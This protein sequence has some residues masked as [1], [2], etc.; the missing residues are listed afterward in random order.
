MQRSRPDWLR[1]SLVRDR[2]GCPVCP[3]FRLKRARSLTA[4]D[5]SRVL[6]DGQRSANQI[7]GYKRSQGRWC[8]KR[9]EVSGPKVCDKRQE[10]G[11]GQADE[12]GTTARRGNL[13]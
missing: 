3:G 13:T 2:T 7:N 6:E 5:L 4:E 10:A 9:P 12:S 11:T 8:M 1:S